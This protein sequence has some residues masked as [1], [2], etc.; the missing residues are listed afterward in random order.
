MYLE[1]FL[2]AL[3]IRIVDHY[4][5]VKTTRTEQCAVKNVRSVGSGDYYNALVCTEAVHF[6]KQLV[7]GLLALVVTAAKACASLT[8]DSID[9]IYKYNCRRIFL[10]LIEQVSYTR[11][12][13]T[14]KHLNK[15]R[16]GY[17]EERHAGF[18][19]NCPCKQ[20][21][22]CSGRS[23][24]QNTLRYPRAEL[25]ELF[26]VLEE[27]HD[28]GHFLFFLIG[29]GNICKGGFSLVV[30]SLFDARLAEVHG[31]LVAAHG[32]VHA[33]HEQY[34]HNNDKREHYKCR[35]HTHKP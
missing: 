26:G 17:R 8:S 1:Y 35:Q 21:L 31:H 24:E 34:P 18:T 12:A 11:C 32:V 7:K 20:G 2:S 16:T 27:L 22:T 5:T 4:L 23:D 30:L 10:C 14:D 33:A 25:I 15:V 29:S 9:L 28:L 13:D 6:D 3:Y 19:C